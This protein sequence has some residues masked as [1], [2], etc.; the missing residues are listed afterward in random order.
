M[1]ESRIDLSIVIPIYN[2]GSYLSDCLDSL[3]NSDG[4]SDTELILI[5][6]GSTDLSGDIADSYAERYDFISCIH[7]SNEGP[8]A[9]RNL[10]LNR[11][12]GKFV[13]FCD[14]DDKVDPAKFSGSQER[15]D[16]T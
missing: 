7:T 14:S 3:L 13:F 10:G 6:D 8:S 5:D 15:A 12:K 16:Q 2:T 4:I 1:K 11:S 9:A